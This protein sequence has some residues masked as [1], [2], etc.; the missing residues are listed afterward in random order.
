M[1]PS[2][3]PVLVLPSFEEFEATYPF[4]CEQHDL[5]RSFAF[6]PNQVGPRLFL[7]SQFEARQKIALRNLNVRY[8]LNA[9]PD[10]PFYMELEDD[11]IGHCEYIRFSI[12]DTFSE[13][14][15]TTL[16]VKQS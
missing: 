2:P 9:T 12:V 6:Y 1:V 11:M 14:S 13:V 8:V 7:G 5:F 16:F 3:T 4:V 15:F 10:L